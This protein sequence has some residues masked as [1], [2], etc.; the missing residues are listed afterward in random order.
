M[1]GR[2]SIGCNARQTGLLRRH[3][4]RPGAYP[5]LVGSTHDPRFSHVSLRC[6][7]SPSLL[8]IKG[9]GNSA[10]AMLGS[11]YGDVA[12][13]LGKGEINLTNETLDLVPDPAPTHKQ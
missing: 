12:V 3:R 11:A 8:D 1:G 10:E 7:L 13:L 2:R 4:L 5:G 9:R 6:F